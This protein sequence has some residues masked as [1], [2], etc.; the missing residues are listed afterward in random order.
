MPRFLVLF[1]FPLLAGCYAFGYPVINAT[2]AVDVDAPDVH[3]FLVSSGHE[4]SGPAI[5]G[6]L[7]FWHRV[8]EVPITAGQVVP[9]WNS[10][11]YYD[12]LVFPILMGEYS[13]DKTI[14]LYRPGYETVVVP[15]KNWWN[16]CGKAPLRVQWKEAPDLDA[17]VKA[18]EQIVP[19]S[20]EQFS[21]HG[22]NYEP[23]VLCFAAQE[24]R[25]L[26]ES[27]QAEGPDHQTFRDELLSRARKLEAEG[28]SEA[29]PSSGPS[30]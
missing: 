7:S 23:E 28:R 19:T 4:L 9:Q 25:R 30:E 1:V 13:Q 26:A 15:V 18:L 21:F 12:Y 8:K 27:K 5:T 17:Q 20:P 29:A 2:P 14:L 24:Y 11:F 16:V 6:P 10:H 22:H 3:A